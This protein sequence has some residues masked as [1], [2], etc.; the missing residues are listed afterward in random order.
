MLDLVSR[1]VDLSF[2]LLGVGRREQIERLA[3]ARPSPAWRS[4]PAAARGGGA[5]RAAANGP[6]A[7]SSAP[8]SDASDIDCR[9]AHRDPPLGLLRERAERRREAAL[10]RR[11]SG[12]SA[13]FAG[14]RRRGTVRGAVPSAGVDA[15]FGTV[16]GGV[17]EPRTL[18]GGN[19]VDCD[20][21]RHIASS[22]ARTLLRS[23]TRAPTSLERA[24][25]GLRGLAS[26]FAFTRKRPS[27]RRALQIR[28]GQPVVLSR[29]PARARESR[30]ARQSVAPS[31]YTWNMRHA[32]RSS[33]RLA[34]ERFP[35]RL[36]LPQS[37]AAQITHSRLESC[38]SARP[39]PKLVPSFSRRRIRLGVAHHGAPSA[40][41]LRT[42]KD[43]PGRAWQTAEEAPEL[44]LL[45]GRGTR[46]D[47]SL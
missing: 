36:R 3:E 15:R 38:N 39:F 14:G 6:Q 5:E 22:R 28:R 43:T 44:T 19:D 9:S 40:W 11:R 47:A 20:R 29:S 25:V 21:R 32:H 42:T 12:A 34:R 4:S 27:A 16:A 31:T 13:A 10:D 37:C 26:M 1:E 35:R 46:L 2:A 23:C 45:F 18:S 24:H 17:V 7:P 33:H 8:S 41:V 30:R